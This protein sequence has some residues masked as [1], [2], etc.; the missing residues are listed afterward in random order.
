[1]LEKAA[2]VQVLIEE[3][4]AWIHLD[5]A[6]VADKEESGATGAMV[7]TMANLCRNK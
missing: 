6:G 2:V 3:P 7:R 5:I 1:M 4:V